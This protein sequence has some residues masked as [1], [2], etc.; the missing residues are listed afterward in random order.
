MLGIYIDKTLKISIT[1][2]LCSQLRALII[3]GKLKSG[4]KLPPT[5][6]LAEELNISRNVVIEAYEELIAEGFLESIPG[7][8]TYV[9][10]DINPME[11]LKNK[12]VKIF[13]RI[14]SKKEDIIDFMSGIP[15]LKFFPS[16]QWMK[17][18]KDSLSSSYNIFS[19]NDIKGNEELREEI[20][21]YLFRIRGIEVSPEQ[22]ITVS[23]ASQGYLLIA[24]ALTSYE[25]IYIEEPT[26]RFIPNIFKCFEYKLKPIEVD[27]G[28]MKVEEIFPD[29]DKA[30]ILL[31]PSHQFPTGSILSIQRRQKIIDWTKKTESLI[32]E[33]DYD[34]EFRFKGVPIPPLWSLDDERV[35]YVG[36][37]SKN[38]SPSLR[39]GFLIVPKKL[40]NLF[41]KIK[42]ELNI[43]TSSIEEKTLAF[44]IKNGFLE[45][46]IY[47]MNKLYKKKRN[48]LEEVLKSYFGENIIIEG[49]SAGLH[50]GVS[51]DSEKYKNID[52]KRSL[53]YKVKVY[54]FS[55]YSFKNK[56]YKNK[57]VLGY[58]NLT[59]DEIKEG[60]KRIYN[61]LE[62]VII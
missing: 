45:R 33:D 30:L 6:K 22:V 14:K 3:E 59:L 62:N 54:E 36:T 12:E 42:Y 52:W 20:S 53:E 27:N 61:F 56:D 21:N 1:N 17:C 7:S 28:G 58:G 40:I 24:R 11:S 15:D 19:Y 60:A 10:S 51:F 9:S 41:L 55:R 2:Q 37:F 48:L 29:K 39:L 38:L 43:Y 13:K 5:R 57:I 25:K 35:I 46:Y 44:F 34:S 47:K 16:K 50:M 4:D 31:T 23:G 8:G 18:L 26:V 49:N 32:I